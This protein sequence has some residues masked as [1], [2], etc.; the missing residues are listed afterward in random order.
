MSSDQTQKLVPVKIEQS[1][2][3][4]EKQSHPSF[5]MVGMSH[6]SSNGMP[7]VG[8]AVMHHS[9][10]RMTIK[11][12]VKYRDK[13]SERFH[14]IRTV[15]EV[16]LSHAQ[17]AEM[18]FSMNHGDG[19]PCTINYV[20]GDIGYRPDPPFESPIK[21]STD[22]LKASLKELLAKSKEMAKEAEELLKKPTPN[23]ADKERIKFLAYKIQQDIESNIGFAAQCVDE[24]MEKNVAHADIESF[25]N[26]KFIS[27]GIEHLKG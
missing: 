10:V 6:I 4:E 16:T 26:M 2:M 8:S 18:L 17:L 9:C 21:Q 22:D 15:A 19:V 12:A 1:E 3:G 13:Y 14:G 7:L 27:A 11:E 5:G 25:V 24:K 20:K 23:K